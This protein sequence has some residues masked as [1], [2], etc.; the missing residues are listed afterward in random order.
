MI[1]VILP[2]GI[3]Q[4]NNMNRKNMFEINIYIYIYPQCLLS[5]GRDNVESGIIQLWKTWHIWQR[6]PWNGQEIILFFDVMAQDIEQIL[7]PEQNHKSNSFL[8]KGWKVYR[9]KKKK[10]KIHMFC[11]KLEFWYIFSSTANAIL[12]GSTRRHGSLLKKSCTEVSKGNFQICCSDLLY[13]IQLK[14]ITLQ[15]QIYN[16]SLMTSFI[17]RKPFLPKL[18]I[19]TCSIESKINDRIEQLEVKQ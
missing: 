3:L 11:K 19:C 1:F 6:I 7:C 9:S 15:F 16:I 18:Y 13:L 12:I 4:M 14:L 5:V 17:D 2:H 10:T 8:S